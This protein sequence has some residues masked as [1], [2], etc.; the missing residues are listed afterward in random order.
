MAIVTRKLID[1][2]KEIFFLH[3]KSILETG[4]KTK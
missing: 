3:L 4:E 2:A 1:C